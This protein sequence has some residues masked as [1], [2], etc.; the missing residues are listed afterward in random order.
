M[1]TT[2]LTISTML[3][4]FSISFAQHGTA[5]S[6]YYPIGFDGDTW[7]GEVSA[8]SDATREIIL[9]YRDVKHNKTQKF[10]AELPPGYKVHPKDGEPRE[11]KPSDIPIGTRVVI[12]YEEKTRKVE[13]KKVKYNEII[14]ISKAPPDRN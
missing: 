9:V 13:G 11:L 10:V 4:V 2:L 5:G 7:T 12:Y 14:Q 1:K 8:V 3:F 6:G